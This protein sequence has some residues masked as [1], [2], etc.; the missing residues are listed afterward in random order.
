MKTLSNSIH[1][2][3]WLLLLLSVPLIVAIT[4]QNGNAEGKGDGGTDSANTPS[5]AVVRD[6]FWPVGYVPEWIKNAGKK[7]QALEMEDTGSSDWSAAMKQ[8][9]IQ[10][11]S[12]SGNEFYAV[13][14]GEVKSVGESVSVKYGNSTYSWAVESISPPSSVKLRRISVK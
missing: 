6:P 12:Q 10:G 2:R 1:I 7:N 3:P 8:V 5:V 14:N 4:V 9:A 13:I 11:I